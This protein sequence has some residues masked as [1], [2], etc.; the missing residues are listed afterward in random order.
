MSA[1]APSSI[2]LARSDVA[3]VGR[4]HRHAGPLGDEGADLVERA[5]HA[6]GR[7]DEHRRRRPGRR[8]AGEH[9][10]RDEQGDECPH[11]DIIVGSS[12]NRAPEQLGLPTILPHEF[13]VN[14]PGSVW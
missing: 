10:Q 6:G 3:G 7:K 14:V 4:L 12:C 11:G 2:C 13:S 9:Q 5:L 8:A 1:G